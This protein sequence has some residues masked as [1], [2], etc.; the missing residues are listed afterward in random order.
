MLKLFP[1]KSQ[2]LSFHNQ[3]Q[4]YMHSQNFKRIT[5]FLKCTTFL[6]TW[7][8]LVVDLTARNTKER[9]W[10]QFVKFTM[11]RWKI[12]QRNLLQ[13]MGSASFKCARIYGL[14]SLNANVS[15]RKQFHIPIEKNSISYKVKCSKRLLNSHKSVTSA[16]LY[17]N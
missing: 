2:N 1:P 16:N 15:V 11:K 10:T 3:W 14:L 13:K 5:S 6:R 4:F 17:Q 7:K 8:R 9:Q 12:T